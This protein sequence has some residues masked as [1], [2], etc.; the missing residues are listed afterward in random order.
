MIRSTSILL[1]LL[2]SF[3]WVYSQGFDTSSTQKEPILFENQDFRKHYTEK[4]NEQRR[5]GYIL[6]GVG[7]TTGLIGVAIISSVGGFTF[8]GSSKKG[9]GAG[10]LLVL[11][12]TIITIIGVQQLISSSVNEKKA[13]AYI[14]VENIGFNGNPYYNTKYVSVGISIAL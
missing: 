7:V 5:T 4:A 13:R 8:Y 11:T 12:G 1:F 10:V 14:A 2:F 9:E 6:L 3:Q